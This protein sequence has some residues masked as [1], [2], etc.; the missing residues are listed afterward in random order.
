MAS[1][2]PATPPN[3]KWT[4]L[5]AAGLCALATAAQAQVSD[6]VIRIGFVSDLSGIYAT[7]SA[8]R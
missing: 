5:A 3:G 7:P 2:P 6:N 8:L 1:Q 4:A